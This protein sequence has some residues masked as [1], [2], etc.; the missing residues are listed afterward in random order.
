MIKLDLTLNNEICWYVYL[1]ID[2]SLMYLFN[3]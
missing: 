2:V 1:Q 3:L